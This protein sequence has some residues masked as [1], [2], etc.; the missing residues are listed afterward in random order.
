MRKNRIY[1]DVLK[2]GI[3]VAALRRSS[4]VLRNTFALMRMALFI[5]LPLFILRAEPLIIDGRHQ[6][7]SSNQNRQS[8]LEQITRTDPYSRN[9]NPD[10]T[11]RQNMQDATMNEQE[12]PRTLDDLIELLETDVEVRIRVL[13]PREKSPYTGRVLSY[14]EAVAFTGQGDLIRSQHTVLFNSETDIQIQYHNDRY[15]LSWRKMRV[16]VLPHFEKEIDR[17]TQNLSTAL[18]QLQIE[19]RNRRFIFAEYGLEAGKEYYARL[20]NETYH[21]PPEGPDEPPRRRTNTTLQISDRSFAE[22]PQMTPMY[23][24]WTY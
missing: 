4:A 13:E 10:T 14:L 23:R 3:H 1:I 22:E 7:E 9:Q 19:L 20:H 11:D 16:M 8:A 12:H 18:E 15:N 6:D 21:L 24:T 2:S 5:V 17:D